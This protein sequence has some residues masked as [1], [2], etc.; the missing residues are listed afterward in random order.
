VRADV[1]DATQVADNMAGIIASH[2]SA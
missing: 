2:S 1:L